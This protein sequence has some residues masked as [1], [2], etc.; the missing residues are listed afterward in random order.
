VKAP[1]S[2]WRPSLRMARREAL[3]ARGRSML[4]L[5]MIALPVLAVTAADV[6][7]ATQSIEGSEALDR[8]LGTADALV[9]F[10]SG[11]VHVQQAFDP[12]DGLS[13]TSESDAPARTLADVR[14]VLGRDARGIERHEGSV[15]FTTGKG[16]GDAEVTEV[17][18][19][20]PLADG[21]FELT[22]GRLP[23]AQD[24]VVVNADLVARGPG[25]GD[26][27]ELADGSTRRI[28]GIAESTS[29]RGHPIAVG[30]P[31]AFRLAGEDPDR[32]WLV[33]GGS[34]SW[35]EVRALNAIGAT[36][37]SRSVI[38]DPP[39]DSE[40]PPEVA[41]WGGTDNSDEVAVLVLVV[42]MALLEVVLLAGP[43]FAVTA[44][45]QSRTLALMAA[46]G[47]TPRQARR[48]ILAG[49]LVLGSAA[50]AL[51]V[52]L[53]VGTGWAVLPL[54]QHFSDA[55]LGPFDV[56]WLHLLG[57]AGLGLA[58]AVLAAVVPAWIASRQ[59]VVAV[60]AGRRGDRRPS[61]RSPILGVVLLGI[62]VAIAAYG[63]RA[64]TGGE[65][66]IAIAAVVAVLGMI[67][68]VPV[69]VVA[70]ARM[71]GR[72][73]LV[74]RYA[75]RDAARHRTRTVP[76]VAAVAATVAGVVALGIALSSDA[77]EN[78][79][80][81]VPQLPVGTGLVYVGEL[82]QDRLDAAQ[83]AVTEALPGATVTRFRGVQD[84]QADG[85]SRYVDFAVRGDDEPG[86]LLSGWSSSL[87]ASVLVSDGEVP[88]V[89]GL[90]DTERARA[91]RTLGGGGV[92]AFTDHAVEASL[93]TA[94]VEEYSPDGEII[95]R[96]RVRLPATFT[97]TTGE[98]GPQA[99]VAPEAARRM[100]LS[101][102]TVSLA[103]TGTE[104]S[105]GAEQDV[106]EALGA[107][108]TGTS[109]NVERGYRS[110]QATVIVQWVLAALGAVLMLGGTLT[111]TFLA[112]S[113]ARPDLA[114]LAAVG[115]SPRA[116]RGV[117][118]SYALVV[119]LVGSLLGA[120]VGFVPGVAVTYPLTGNGYRGDAAPVSHYLDVPWLLIGTLVLVLPLVTA[121]VVGLAAR[122]R[123]P[124]VARLD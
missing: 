82:D 9:R 36:V 66:P 63:A 51:G 37:A 15:R 72:L 68:L 78:Q 46:G 53:G 115:A 3:R 88:A 58:S 16:I 85:S 89:L 56:P 106:R 122:S 97:L 1:F 98:S 67:L 25:P 75:V 8:R 44:R 34:V 111:A 81:Y 20:D 76:A 45:R 50:A 83:D 92:V 57:I 54:V 112:L 43:A 109:F 12:E 77:A 103:V 30:P 124:M 69:V 86:G 79:A 60:L 61:V 105:D 100:G 11:A 96:H 14:R 114:T 40:L 48:V 123:L 35:D 70:L 23:A 99:L 87:G 65:F 64:A 7:I 95:G 120:A 59:D 101:V 91:T 19:R 29:Y 108:G 62:G 39:P 107:I 113:D 13:W 10:S 17:D 33:E 117:A 73:P 74:L 28:V 80:T 24:E 32:T 2:G 6:V 93:V 49:G 31:G 110:D 52:V 116:R 21:L 38:S 90:T 104:I 5:V 55:R 22:T 47:G 102:R 27:L 118:A 26:D 71:S 121:L 84:G 119:G 42:V 4:V 18:L 94:R 41:A